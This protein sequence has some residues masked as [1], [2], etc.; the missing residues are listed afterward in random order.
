MGAVTV[1]PQGVA[2]LARQGIRNR[3]SAGTRWQTAGTFAVD[4]AGTVRWRHLPRD[5]ADLP[6]LKGLI[7]T[8]SPDVV[9]TDIRMPPTNTDEGIAIAALLR[10]KHPEMG[11]LL[12]S[13]YAEA[14]YALTL[15]LA[16]GDLFSR[17]VAFS[18][19][20]VADV[21]RRGSPRFFVSHGT[22]DTILPIETCGRRIAREFRGLGY[23]VRF[24]EFDGGH[25]VPPDVAEAAMDW[26]VKPA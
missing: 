24:L 5:A 9:V 10:T 1:G 20:F 3:H 11:V 19:G 15:G 26:L 16:N 8:Q 14:S 23:G 25:A 13:Q 22:R 21:V 2:R 17:V 18:P 4:G 12:L 6:A 7:E